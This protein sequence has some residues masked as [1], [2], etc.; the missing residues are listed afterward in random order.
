MPSFLFVHIRFGAHI[1]KLLCS[2]TETTVCAKLNPVI[3]I[4]GNDDDVDNKFIDY[5]NNTTRK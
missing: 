4:I 3:L 5:V 1:W 2:S